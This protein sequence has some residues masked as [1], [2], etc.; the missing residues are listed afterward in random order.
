M[1]RV[2]MHVG[3]VKHAKTQMHLPRLVRLMLMI[4][5]D[6]SQFFERLEKSAIFTKNCAKWLKLAKLNIQIY[7]SKILHG[8]RLGKPFLDIF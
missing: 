7:Y 8:T 3:A 5:K 2:Q 6:F 4:Q 1:L